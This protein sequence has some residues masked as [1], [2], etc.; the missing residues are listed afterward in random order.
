M[1][2]ERV[3][4][5][6]GKIIENLFL[7]NSKVIY[8]K[9]G[10]FYESWNDKVFKDLIDE[11]AN[12]VQDNHSKSKRGVLRGLHYQLEP[13]AQGKL[14]RCTKGKIFDVALD[15]RKG[16]K[17]YKQHFGTILDD[18]NKT[19]FWIPTGFAHGF[20]A[21]SEFA[22]VQYKTINF[23]NKEFERSIMWNDPELNIKWPFHENNILNPSISEKDS[24]SLTMDEA[25]KTNNIFL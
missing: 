13:F 7:I 24:N 25:D 15:L 4:T 3:K 10:F 21:L 20:L 18:L 23:W 12:F 9:R 17:T 16:S 14:V 5:C 11:K 19:Q 6:D 1:N 22:E 8:D 2:I